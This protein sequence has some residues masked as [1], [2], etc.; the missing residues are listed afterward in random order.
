MKNSTKIHI[1]G[2]YTITILDTLGEGG[3]GAVYKVQKDDG[4]GPPQHLALKILKDNSGLTRFLSE[5]NFGRTHGL[6]NIIATYDLIAIRNHVG[7]IVPFLESEMTEDSIPTESTIGYTMQYLEGETAEDKMRE[8][9]TWEQFLTALLPIAETLDTLHRDGKIHRDIKPPNIMISANNKAFLIDFGLHKDFDNSITKSHD[10][11]GT[12]SYIAHEAFNA[13]NALP[14]SDQYSFAMTVF[15]LFFQGYPWG[16][17]R[18]FDETLSIILN[19]YEHFILEHSNVPK[20]LKPIFLKA[21]N[22]DFSKRYRSCLEF[23]QAVDTSKPSPFS[24]YIK[25]LAIWKLFFA[26]DGE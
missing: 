5:Y 4:V 25:N 22:P 24:R 11:M 7:H 19:G 1:A 21:L 9:W 14:E 6:D 23:L 10:L 26:H 2:K 16:R 15:Y 3:Q 8:G 17:T 12:P 20:E 18:S 13:K